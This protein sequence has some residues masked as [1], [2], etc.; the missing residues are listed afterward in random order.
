MRRL[1]TLLVAAAIAMGLAL[2]V[3]AQSSLCRLYLTDQY[4]WG[5]NLGFYL[6]LEGKT[7][8]DL[9]LI[10]GVAD[11][12]NW[13]FP[14]YRPGFVRDRDYQIHAVVAPDRAQLYLDGNLVADSPGGFRPAAGVLEANSRPGWA[15]E[16]GDWIGLVSSVSVSVIRGGVEVERRDFDLTQVSAR[17]VPLQLLAGTTPTSSALATSPGDTVAIDVSMRFADANPASWAPFLDQYGQCRYADWP[18]KVLSDDDLTGDL[19]REDAELALMPPSPDYDEYGGYLKAGWQEPP[20]GFFRVVQRDGYWW[21]ISPAGNPCFYVGVCSVPARTFCYTP[22]TERESFFSWLPPHEDPWTL[23]WGRDP[24]GAGEDADYLSYYACN[25]IRKYAG[26]WWAASE[27][28]AV[29]RLKSWGFSGG[30]K[31]GAPATVVATPVLSRSSALN[32]VSH[33]DVFDSTVCAAFRAE[34]SAQIAPYTTNPMILGWTVGSER[35]ELFFADEITQ[36]LAKP[37]TAP[38]K[39]ALLDYAVDQ[40]YG[41]SVAALAAGWGM[42]V[43]TRDELYASTPTPTA[44]DLELMRKRYADEYYRFVYTTV[45]SLDPNHLYLGCYICPVCPQNDGNWRLIAAHC[46]VMSYDR[47]TASYE[48]GSLARLQREVGKP[49]FCGEFSFPPWYEGWRGFGRYGVYSGDDADAGDSYARW[50]QA[51]ATDPYCVGVEWFEYR[52]QPLTGRG[53]GHGP[54]LVYGEHYA[55]GLITETDRP[56]WP[57]VR[58]M[59]ETNLQAAQWRLEAK[60][61]PFDDVPPDYWA[62]REIEAC[63]AAGIVTGYADGTYRPRVTVTRAQMAVY[64]ARALAG[65]DE[66]VPTGPAQGHFSDIATDYWAYR[67]IEFAFANAVVQGYGDATYR[68]DAAVNRAQ[69]AVFIARA[70]VAPGGDA[71]IPDPEPPPSFTDVAADFWAYKQIEYIWSRGVTEGYYDGT[72]R[73]DYTCTRDQM[74]VYVARAFELAT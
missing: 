72:Y 68:P 50:V 20:T 38:A 34:L 1:I 27:D 21:L 61:G 29:R 41:G 25:L 59:R 64:V 9:P 23:A 6:D 22:V 70:L 19:A 13:R 65:G 51:A 8:A 31:W 16:S 17:P 69:M 26:G 45:K 67:H 42:T 18:E 44:S 3:S 62:A 7:L 32:L 30:G 55:F 63:V 71:A 35:A 54:D 56:K 58:R 36:V 28:R 2:P 49:T 14:L 60:K 48:D 74:A 47:Y 66:H 53:P 15:S 12:T 57:L 11:G 33:P 52:D 10:L 4:D 40:L 73:P 24:W 46:D 5:G 43:T 37:A 39:R